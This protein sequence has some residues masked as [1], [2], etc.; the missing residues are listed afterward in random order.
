MPS[1]IFFPKLCKPVKLHGQNFHGGGKVPTQCRL[2]KILQ[3][4]AECF[5][6]TAFSFEAQ[7]KQRQAGRPAWRSA[8]SWVP[9]KGSSWTA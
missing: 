4:E 1:F 3:L 7:P 6:I 9:G 2:D 5:I 8:S